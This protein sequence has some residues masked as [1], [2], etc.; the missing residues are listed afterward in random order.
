M[1]RV[2]SQWPAIAA[3]ARALGNA[4][5]C[6]FVLLVLL[7]PAEMSRLSAG[8]FVSVPLEVLLGAAL[9]LALPM[10]FRAVAATVLGVALGLLRHLEAP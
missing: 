3:F 9:L 4:L 2:P 10:T 8:A 5:A 6:L 7:A 1:M